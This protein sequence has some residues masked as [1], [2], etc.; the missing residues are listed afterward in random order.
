MAVQNRW[1]WDNYKGK[2][3]LINDY[4]NLLNEEILQLIKDNTL[5]YA[6][7]QTQDILLLVDVTN[8]P[9]DKNIATDLKKIANFIQPK[10]KKSAC[11]GV[12][13]LQKVILDGVN[14]FSKL[15]IKPFPSEEQAKEW[16]VV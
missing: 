1:R 7:E 8:C 10:V 3:I 11:I 14:H 2:K 13:G 16:L 12:T 4:S 9:F 15:G 6:A 5:R